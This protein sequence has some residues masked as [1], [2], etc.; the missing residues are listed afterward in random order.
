MSREG[1]V[2]PRQL[3]KID[4]IDEPDTMG[5]DI[6]ATQKTTTH[7]KLNEINIYQNVELQPGQFH[8]IIIKN[9]DQKAVLTWDYESVK[10]EVLF[11]IYETFDS[12]YINVT[13]GK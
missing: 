10:T 6:T 11:T 1:G 4:S 2:I 7:I 8:E 12:A 9:D 13:N 5:D 3:Y